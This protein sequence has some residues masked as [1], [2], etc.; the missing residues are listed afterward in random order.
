MSSP[1]LTL[2]YRSLSQ[3]FDEGL[4][5]F[6][7]SDVTVGE[8]MQIDPQA[9]DV[10]TARFTELQT[11]ESFEAAWEEVKGSNSKTNFFYDE[12]T[13]AKKPF[14][15]EWQAAGWTSAVM[16]STTYGV[17]KD[18]PA[19]SYSL[20]HQQQMRAV[21]A[22]F[23]SV[24]EFRIRYA[25]MKCCTTGRNF[26]LGGYSNITAPLCA[27]Q[28]PSPPS[29]PPPAAPSPPALPP[30]PP[31][32]PLHVGLSEITRMLTRLTEDV[33]SIKA[34]VAQTKAELAAV[35]A[36][37]SGI[38]HTLTEPGRSCGTGTA[39]DEDSGACQITCASTGRTLQDAGS[40]ALFR[41]PAPQ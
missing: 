15:Q 10:Q 27:P 21:I 22:M 26:F 23:E 9:K 34:D 40:S 2:T 17:G 5:R 18:N 39:W 24:T 12:T 38:E 20:T 35:K 13:G 36:D 32:S 1:P 28:P 11:Y 6:D 25:I 31:Y 8:A 4:G 41:P 30:L 14:Y 7:E 33:A 16:T 37:V 3:D 29:L 19:D